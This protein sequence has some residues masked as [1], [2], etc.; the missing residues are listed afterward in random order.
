MEKYKS[1]EDYLERIYMLS[2]TSKVR[3]IDIATDM[4]FTKASVSIAMKK[5]RENGYITFDGNNYIELTES[6]KAL[7][8]KI[9]EKHVVISQALMILGVPESIASEDACMIEHVL[10]D[11]S[12]EAIKQHICKYEERWITLKNTHKLY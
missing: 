1:A 12:F 4:G 3:A 8:I 10:S 11:T 2:K 7:A 6:G 9:Y 5:L